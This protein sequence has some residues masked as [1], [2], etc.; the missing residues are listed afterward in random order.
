MQKSDA[1]SRLL[2]ATVALESAILAG[3][4]DE[5]PTLIAQRDE[6]LDALEAMPFDE[7][8]RPTLQ[9]VRSIDDRI[10]AQL[11]AARAESSSELF[12]RSSAQ[13]QISNYASRGLAASVVD[14]NG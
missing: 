9:T 4:F 14:R 5:A 10:A 8:W 2:S 3:Q 6:I 13:R 11:H 7:T 12:K 1:V